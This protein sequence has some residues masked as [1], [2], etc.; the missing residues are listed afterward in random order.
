MHLS[1]TKLSTKTLVSEMTAAAP[2]LY[3]SSQGRRSL[4]YLLLPRTRRH[5]T[6][7]QIATLGETDEARA[8]TSKKAT[9]VREAEVR[10]GASTAILE[11]LKESAADVSREPGGSLLVTEV[12]LYADGGQYRF[13]LIRPQSHTLPQTSPLSLRTCSTPSLRH[14]RHRN[15]PHSIPLICLIPRGCTRHSYKVATSARPRNPS[16]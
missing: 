9:E 3:S 8:R 6:P 4:I 10:A 15:H 11:W 12:M 7:A 2:T 5:F 14:I 1:D 16:T 13:L